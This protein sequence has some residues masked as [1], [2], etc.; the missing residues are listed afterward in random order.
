MKRE[1]HDLDM[2]CRHEFDEIGWNVIEIFDFLFNTLSNT[3]FH[4]NGIKFHGIQEYHGIWLE[5]KTPGFSFKITCDYYT[6]DSFS[7]WEWKYNL[8]THILWCNLFPIPG[9]TMKTCSFTID[10][11]FCASIVPPPRILQYKSVFNPQMQFFSTKSHS[12]IQFCVFCFFFF[13][14]TKTNEQGNM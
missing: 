7:S 6:F 9:P 3:L 2:Y 14:F 5:S 1:V 11:L 12:K 8:F 10:T 13:F 4:K